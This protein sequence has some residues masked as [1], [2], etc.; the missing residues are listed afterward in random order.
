MNRVKI[1]FQKCLKD[2]II[3]FVILTQIM[4]LSMNYWKEENQR[5]Q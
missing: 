1:Y 4:A 5:A 3:L 2:F